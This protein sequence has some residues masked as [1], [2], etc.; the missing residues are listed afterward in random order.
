[1]GSLARPTKKDKLRFLTLNWVKKNIE[2]SLQGY[3]DGVEW[4]NRRTHL[5]IL[6]YRIREA[7]LCAFRRMCNVTFGGR[8]TDLGLPNITYYELGVCDPTV[9]GERTV[10][11]RL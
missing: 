9:M 8:N 6:D 1:M 3:Y 11:S 2:Y 10:M 4:C 5:C 7:A